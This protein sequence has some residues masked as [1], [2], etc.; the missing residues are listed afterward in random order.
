M[1]KDG[2][3][4]DAVY[5]ILGGY[6]TQTEYIPGPMNNHPQLSE[7][8]ERIVDALRSIYWTSK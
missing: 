1:S 7:T 4:Q 8:V 5:E 3:A 2:R 6:S